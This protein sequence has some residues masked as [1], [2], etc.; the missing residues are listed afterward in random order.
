MLKLIGCLADGWVPSSP[1]ASPDRLPAMHARIDAATE[2]AGRK[3]TDIRRV[4]NLSGTITDGARG[5]YLE[6]PVT[7]WVEEL[8]HLAAEVGKD[9]FVFWLLGDPTSQGA[10]LH[11]RGRAG[12]ACLG[13]VT[14]ERVKL[15]YRWA[16]ER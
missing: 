13:G 4:Y 16:F 5:E 1:W 3:P 9:S 15:S 7:Y 12:G 14:S 11:R 10:S 2:A 6:G 8:S